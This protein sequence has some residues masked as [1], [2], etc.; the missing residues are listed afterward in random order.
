MQSSHDTI[1]Q[2][3]DKN[4]FM[5]ETSS[6]EY[7]DGQYWEPNSVQYQMLQV[8][9]NTHINEAVHLNFYLH[10]FFTPNMLIRISRFGLLRGLVKTSATMASVGQHFNTTTFFSICSLMK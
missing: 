9:Y 8:K 1:M 10:N 3:H 6:H 7:A 4:M 2:Y 5:T